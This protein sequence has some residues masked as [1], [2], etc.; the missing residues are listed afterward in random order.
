MSK[1]LP[2]DMIIW[3]M[4]FALHRYADDSFD[5]LVASS[6]QATSAAILRHASI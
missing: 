4:G 5:R 3:G 6:G 2:F 1:Y